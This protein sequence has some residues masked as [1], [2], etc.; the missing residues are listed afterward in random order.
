MSQ[1][2]KVKTIHSLSRK[3]KK[4]NKRLSNK[5][6]RQSDKLYYENHWIQFES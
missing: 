6:I 1:K 4:A 2:T 5:K 3:E